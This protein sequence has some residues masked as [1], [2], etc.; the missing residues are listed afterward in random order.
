PG[1]LKFGAGSN[2]TSN[3][4]L[5]VMLVAYDHNGQPL[6][7]VKKK[8]EIPLPP[9][10]YAAARQV[11]LQLHFEIDV[12]KGDFFLRTGIYDL[13]SGEAGTLGIPSSGISAPRP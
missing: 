10:A 5:E 1:D 4:N 7:L 8:G 9:E 11:G 6:N 12:P 2:G 3:A 13:N